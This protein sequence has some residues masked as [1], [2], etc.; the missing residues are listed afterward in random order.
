[1][2]LDFQLVENFIANKARL[3]VPE[4]V[5][6]MK[7]PMLSIHGSE[8]PTVPIAAV[9]EIGSWNPEVKVSIIPRAGHTFGAGHPFVGDELPSDLEVVI[10]QSIDFLK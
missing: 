3:Q 6:N 7:I 10:E 9:K 8:D 5:K 4:A 2:P 1:M